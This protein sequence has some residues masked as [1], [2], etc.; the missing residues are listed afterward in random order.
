MEKGEERGRVMGVVVVIRGSKEEEEKVLLMEETAGE[1][2]RREAR[3]KAATIRLWY[4]AISASSIQ[5][6][7]SRNT[8]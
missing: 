4:L 6:A 3:N 1:V 5:L 2:E 8:R 7:Q